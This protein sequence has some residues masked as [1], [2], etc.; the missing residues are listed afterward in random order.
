MLR[1]VE[2]QRS[3][4]CI[5]VCSAKQALSAFFEACTVASAGGE[6]IARQRKLSIRRRRLLLADS[7]NSGDPNFLA[8]GHSLPLRRGRGAVKFSRL[9]YNSRGLFLIFFFVVQVEFHNSLS[10]E[11]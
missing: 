3:P 1:H 2:K 6:R 7:N 5:T 9:F 4:G 8:Q 11:K 10:S